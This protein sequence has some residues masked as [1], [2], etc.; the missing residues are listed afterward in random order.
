MGGGS[1]IVITFL[2][3][4]NIKSIHSNIIKCS[5]YETHVT[6]YEAIIKYAYL[7]NHWSETLMN[8]S[9]LAEV[10]EDKITISHL[11]FVD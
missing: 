5:S 11:I 4:T 8:I 10:T 1:V 2:C 9:K 3:Q 6:E 7:E